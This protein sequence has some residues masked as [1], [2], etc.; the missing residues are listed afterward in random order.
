MIN[1]FKIRDQTCA[2]RGREERE[3]GDIWR[4]NHGGVTEEKDAAEID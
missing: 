2:K 4:P 3:R 1:V